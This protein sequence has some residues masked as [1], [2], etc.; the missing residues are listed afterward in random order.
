[1]GL[2]NSNVASVSET[3]YRKSEDRVMRNPV[4]ESGGHAIWSYKIIE[5]K[6]PKKTEGVEKQCASLPLIFAQV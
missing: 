3:A 2:G 4:G 1:M 6:A 5:I